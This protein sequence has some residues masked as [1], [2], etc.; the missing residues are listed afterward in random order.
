MVEVLRPVDERW[1]IARVNNVSIDG[2]HYKVAYGDTGLEDVVTLE[3]VRPAPPP[4]TA[5]RA[6]VRSAWRVGDLCEAMY[7]EDGV[8]YEAR[9]LEARPNGTFFVIYTEYDNTEERPL[10]FLRPLQRAPL[11]APAPVPA[12]VTRSVQRAPAAPAP[13]PAPVPVP[14]PVTAPSVPAGPA[15]PYN[16]DDVIE[17]KFT[18]DNTWYTARIVKVLDNGRLYEVVYTEY[19][20][21]E[22]LPLERIRRNLSQ[23]KSFMPVT[24]GTSAALIGTVQQ[25]LD[26]F[27]RKYQGVPDEPAPNANELFVVPPEE[28][29]IA[30]DRQTRYTNRKKAVDIFGPRPENAERLAFSD[31]ADALPD[32]NAAPVHI[33][34]LTSDLPITPHQN[35]IL[36]TIEK[37]QVAI[38]KG[39]TGSGKTT[40]IPQYLLEAGWCASG[41]MVGCTQPRRVAATSVAQ[42]VA[43]EMGVKLGEEVGFAIRFDDTWTPGRTRIK[44][45][46]DGML[47]REMMLDPLLLQYSALMLDEAHERSVYTDVIVGLLKK[48]LKK[49][50]DLRLVVSSAT[51]DADEFAAYF[52]GHDG[53]DKV[54]ILSIEGRMHPVDIHY[55]EQPCVSYMG[56]A[57]DTI[58][59]IHANEPPGDVLVFLTGQDEVETLVQQL[60]DAN[61]TLKKGGMLLYPVP[62]YAGLTNDEQQSVFEPVPRG[63]RKVVVATNIA[64]SS[65]TIDGIVYV[66]DCGFV[67]MRVYNFKTNIESLI[68]SPTSQGSLRWC[69]RRGRRLSRLPQHPRSSA[70]AAR[71]ACG[72]ARR[73]GC[74]LRRSLSACGRRLCPRFSAATSCRSCCSSRRSGFTTSLGLTLCRRR[75]PSS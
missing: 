42:R 13:A 4:N 50:P 1:T 71:G 32:Q 64:E 49:R 29:E 75:H 2:R 45:M 53:E 35:R 55:L 57:L 48:V 74:T 28:S 3:R 27:V 58:L 51:L 23:G 61:A 46:T 62:I 39:S 41:R 37:N 47:L 19:D 52:R 25:Q 26:M 31:I 73:T 67:K 54:A 60:G 10:Q 21:S 7:S 44:Y 8:W 56:A 30:T 70:P 14:A 12:P 38:I 18:G 24:S 68:V 69:G 65:V 43:S 40:Q 66:I 59:N 6:V 22:L 72:P 11:A 20:N 9:I 16:V 5:A 33:N 15:T 34:H 63:Y 36:H 17:G